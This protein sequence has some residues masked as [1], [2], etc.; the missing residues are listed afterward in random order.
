MPVI[1][2]D[3]LSKPGPNPSFYA[4][5]SPS[6]MLRKRRLS[7]PELWL[8]D[9]HLK[10]AFSRIQELQQ[11]ELPSMVGDGPFSLLSDECVTLIL[12][13]LP[14]SEQISTSLVCKRW[15]S[16]H[17]RVVDSISLLHLDF[18]YSG[19][20]TSRFPN[21]TEV[22]LVQACFRSSGCSGVLLSHKLVSVHVD[23]D[24][25]NDCLIGEEEFLGSDLIDEGLKMLA[26][27]CPNLRK[28]VLANPSEKG[29]GFVAE[30]CLALQELEIHCCK[31]MSLRSISCFQNLQILKLIGSIDGLYDSSVTD[32]GLTILAHGCRRLVKLELSGCE[33]SYD[34]IKAIGQCCEML[35]ELTL[36]AH[37]MEGGWLSALPYCSNLKTVKLLSCEN[38]D[39]LP[40]P[41]EHLCSCLVLE[42]LYLEQ[43]QMQDKSS[44]KAL[45]LVCESVTE[46]SFKDCWGLDDDTFNYVTICR[47]EINESLSVER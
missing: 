30:P 45:F 16:V 31:D 17:G 46:I 12:S 19:R 10:H 23:P 22:N 34:G 38:I 21:L 5:S 4:I 40:G 35:Q 6:D 24:F 28:L 39:P 9:R 27:G 1:L 14:I 8:K 43:C 2:E 36:R 26:S 20:L 33:G 11:S 25:V 32:I 13:K 42:E 3:Q 29:L 15:Y 7:L 18:L 37:K 47:Y 41:D 44:V